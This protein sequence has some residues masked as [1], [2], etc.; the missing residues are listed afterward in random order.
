MVAYFAP[1]AQGVCL[2]L[3]LGRADADGVAELVR[4]AA[5]S[6]Q[7]HELEVEWEVEPPWPAVPMRPAFVEEV[8]RAVRYIG[9][10]ERPAQTVVSVVGNAKGVFRAYLAFWAFDS[11]DELF[12][13]TFALPC[14]VDCVFKHS[15][16]EP[17]L[18]AAKFTVDFWFQARWCEFDGGYTDESSPRRFKIR[19]NGLMY[20]VRET[21]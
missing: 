7:Y 14:A 21:V 20:R 16:N 4:F 17:G 19:R 13:D 3:N 8:A 18:K 1:V 2:R 10:E 6:V 15:F 12:E 11:E 9:S 5:D